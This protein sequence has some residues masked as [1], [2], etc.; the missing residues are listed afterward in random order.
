MSSPHLARLRQFFFKYGHIHVPNFPE[1]EALFS[2]C[3]RLRL[4]KEQLHPAVVEEL[5]GMG[6]LWDLHVSSEL[7]WYYHYAELKKFHGEFEHTRVPAKR[8]VYKSLGNWVLRQRMNEENLSEKGK[9]LL[10]DIGFEW[11]A[12]IEHKKDVEW[13]TKFRLLQAYY[14]KNGHSNVPDNYEINEKLGRWVSTVRYGEARLAPWKMKL[15]KA[16]RFQFR[17]D[18]VSERMNKRQKLFDKLRQFYGNQGHTNVPEGYLDRRLS[19]FVAYLRQYPTRITPE[20]VRQL[21]KWNFQFS[22]E[23]KEWRNK[24]WMDL[25]RKLEKFRTK[26]KHCR[27]PSTYEDQKLARWVATQRKDQKEGRLNS[28]RASK[29]KAI[30]FDFCHDLQLLRETRWKKMFERLVK[31]RNARGTT[32]VKQTSDDKVLAYWVRHQ[33]QAA[34][35]MNAKKKKMLDEI[36]FVWKMR[37]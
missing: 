6:F 23:L 35:R 27:V 31:F 37:L 22:D 33:R 7:K 13:L 24:N 4:T 9:M 5:N 26:H 1:H 16:V 29:L 20:E 18:I 10:N 12:D 36:G 11:S 14:K 8:G 32:I 21:K 19:I 3:N 15:L 34:K 28:M 2:L 30:G 25:F 17:D